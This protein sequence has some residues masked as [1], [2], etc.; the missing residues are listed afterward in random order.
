MPEAPSAATV[1]WARDVVTVTVNGGLDPGSASQVRERM[2]EVAASRPARLVL[3]LTRVPE[4][5]GAEC[6]AMIAVARHLLPP[7]CA[8]D[9]R[10]ESVAVRQILALAERSAAETSPGKAEDQAV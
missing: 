2:G 9:V 3:D 6:L 5:Y 1:T 10:S 7:G 8:V 4:R